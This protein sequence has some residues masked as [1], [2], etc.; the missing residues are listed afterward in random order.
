MRIAFVTFGNFDG[1][2]TLKRATGMAGPLIANGH[3]VVLLLE[4]C[5]VNKEKVEL[6][7]PNVKVVWHVRGNTA[8]AERRAK[9]ESLNRL[10]PDMVWICG[11]GS[12]NWMRKSHPEC[13]VLADHSELYSK[14]SSG[15]MRCVFYWLLEW[16]YCVSFD[17]HICASRYLERFYRKRLRMLG[18][19]AKVH[20]SPYA[21]H[22]DVI[23]CDSNGGARIRQKFAGKK[24]ILYMGSFW[25]NYG[26][27]DMLEAFRRIALKRDDFIVLMGGRG[28]EKDAGITWVKEHGI[29]E[30]IR[31][32]GYI[33][34][35]E[36]SAYFTAAHAFLS[37]L[38][39]TIQDWARCPSKLYMY[40]PFQR[41]VV[42]CRIGEA[43][44]LFGDKGVYY[45]PSNVD[46]L[47]CAL[48]RVLSEEEG[49]KVVPPDE[50]TYSARTDLFC[51]WVNQEYINEHG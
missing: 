44:E 31:I 12:R 22:P 3:E 32:E 47:V 42:T 34:E 14:V 35:E 21:F 46:S 29:D 28:P 41:P 7:C 16:A 1:H 11:V 27:W 36:L 8:K 4:D 51:E 5:K 23:A 10:Q 9:Q 25:R 38:N 19:Q 6:E 13:L 50:H 37:P 45:E 26:F 24:L 40:L 15:F 33:P 2:A 30:Y 20:Y 48:E 49:A 43:A 17:G 18:K 39:D